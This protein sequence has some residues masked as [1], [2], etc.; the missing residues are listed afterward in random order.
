MTERK[1][2]EQELYR[3]ANFDGL[4]NLVNRGYFHAGLEK[5]VA[6]SRRNGDHLAVSLLD[7]DHFKYVNDHYGHDAGDEMLRCVSARMSECIRSSD[8]AARLG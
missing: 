7:L 4:T 3:L 8:T 6:K 5:A 2:V 1:Q